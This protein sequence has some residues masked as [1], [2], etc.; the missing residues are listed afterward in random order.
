MKGVKRRKFVCFSENGFCVLKKEK[1]KK[2]RVILI[3]ECRERRFIKVLLRQRRSTYFSVDW[4]G[5]WRK[6]IKLGTKNQK[7]QDQVRFAWQTPYIPSKFSFLQFKIYF[8]RLNLSVI[9]FHWSLFDFFPSFMMR[10][11]MISIGFL[12]LRRGENEQNCV[13]R[14]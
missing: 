6:H 4:F 9:E 5:T 8:P 13:G 10:W 2:K 12:F 14:K 3:D 1:R 7:T 11:S